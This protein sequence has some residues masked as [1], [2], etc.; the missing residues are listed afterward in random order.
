LPQETALALT[1]DESTLSIEDETPDW[2]AHLSP[3]AAVPEPEPPQPAPVPSGMAFV[4]DPE[5]TSEE[6]PAWLS[7]LGEPGA[8]T[9]ITALAETPDWLQELEAKPPQPASELEAERPSPFAEPVSLPPGE[10]PAWLKDLKPVET[11]APTTPGT[12]VPEAFV[13]IPSVPGEETGTTAQLPAWLQAL[14]PKETPAAAPVAASQAEPEPEETEGILAGV[15]GPLPIATLAAQ[16]LGAG[17]S[18]SP[19]IPAGDLARAGA[20]QELLARGAETLVRREGE[21]RAQR[22]LSSTQR[23]FVFLIVALAV[24][25]PLWRGFGLAQQPVLTGASE[26]VYNAINLLKPGDPVLVAFDYDAAQSPEMDVLARA[27]LRHL[28]AR[29]AKIQVASLYPAGPAAAQAVLSSVVPVTSAVKMEVVHAGYVPGQA[30][31]AAAL[32]ANA[33]QY[34]LIIELAATPD[35]LR[36]WAEQMTAQHHA[37]LYAAV[38]ASV[39]AVALPYV[40]S[41][42]IKGLL[43]GVPHAVAYQFKLRTLL[44]PL[45]RPS[46]SELLSPVESIGAA[47]AA[48]VL[49]MVLG[50]LFPAPRGDGRGGK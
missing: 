11:S 21:S 6:T 24:I 2:L 49:L 42:Q 43:A 18:M 41:G 13:P 35:T 30:T 26:T 19:A 20:L 36:W 17:V 38:S 39:E 44:P 46:P 45:D 31:A 48:L 12:S 28:A 50:A 4:G 32:A 37:P 23:A 25:A 8:K 16:A 40:D 5:S 3:L 27:V 10:L 34:K 47:I 15:R 22:L 7:D 33:K 1:G 29:Q 9:A 14:S